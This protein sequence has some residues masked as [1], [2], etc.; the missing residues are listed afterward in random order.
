MS[1]DIREA[2]YFN[3]A[4]AD[5]LWARAAELKRQRDEA[6]RRRQLQHRE[7]YLNQFRPRKSAAPLPKPNLRWW[8]C[9]RMGIHP[10]TD[11][12]PRPFHRGEL[13][14]RSEPLATVDED[15]VENIGDLDVSIDAYDPLEG[16]IVDGDTLDLF[17]EGVLPSSHPFMKQNPYDRMWQS[18]G[19][20]LKDDEFRHVSK[21]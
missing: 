18:V 13:V 6:I 4:G 16:W 3:G 7:L 19:L 11:Y 21:L 20:I 10:D 15:V 2:G 9:K 17:Q 5:D 14:P 1:R 8:I 12:E